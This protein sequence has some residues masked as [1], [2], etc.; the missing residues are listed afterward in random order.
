M[1]DAITTTVTWADLQSAYDDELADLREAYDELVAKATE[2]YGADALDQL[3]TD[4][5]SDLR[6]YQ[7]QAEQYD[8]AAKTLQ[9]RQHV[10]ER[11][12]EQYGDGAFEIK[13]LTGSETMDIET[14]LRMEAQQSDLSMEALNIRRNAL[15]VDTAT[16]DA[17]E[18]VPRDDDG[19]PTPS[20]CPNPLTLALWEHVERYNNAG[21]T[22]FRPAGFGEDS[23]DPTPT[24]VASVP[25][26]SA[27]EPS[28][29]SA[30]T[31]EN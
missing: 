30:P 24:D 22:D 31:D 4:D 29:P 2:T 20:E 11:L 14:E 10:I 6:V 17:P 27:S 19:S 9:K 21:A 28:E 1:T 5:D 16:V 15:T 8:Q 26:T 25:P 18:G 23:P 12:A 13:M 7:T 3:V